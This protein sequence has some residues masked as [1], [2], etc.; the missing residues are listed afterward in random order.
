MAGMASE[1]ITFRG[2]GGVALEAEVH[3]DPADPAILL[4]HGLGQTRS[5]WHELSQ[6]LVQS[7]RQVIAL[8]LR[9]HGGSQRPDDGRYDVLAQAA[10]LRAVLAQMRSR[11]VVVA[12]T[13]GGWIATV[14]LADDV[15]NLA[16]GLVLVDM[17]VS[18]EAEVSDRI[19]ARVRELRDTISGDWDDAVLGQIYDSE[20]SARLLAAAPKL[21]VPI[22]VVRGELSW[23]RETPECRLF[24]EALP[25]AEREAIVGSEL[26]V[27]TDRTEV[28]GKV[29]LDFLERRQPRD[30]REFRAGSDAR[31]LRHS[32]GCFATGVTVVT[33]LSDTGQPVGLTVNSFTSVSIDPAHPGLHPEQCRQ[34]WDTQG[35]RP[36]R[37]KRA[38]DQPAGGVEPVREQRRGQ[39]RPDRLDIRRIRSAY[40]AGLA[41]VVC[42]FPAQ[43]P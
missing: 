24:D 5:V 37:D 29:L 28:F 20:T 13:I 18:I 9:G 33:A 15:E 39:V 8:D 22:L 10:D 26:A 23:M 3:G 7:G 1:R 41:G 4:V 32:F 25:D 2:F 14:A 19:L 43:H 16:A 40:P 30:S 21:N 17:P 12:A 42:M 6:W 38:S 11:P 31:T 34:R 36:F 27:V 35:Y